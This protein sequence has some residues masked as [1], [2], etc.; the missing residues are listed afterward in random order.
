[1]TQHHNIDLGVLGNWVLEVRRSYRDNPFHNWYHGF[2]VLH[3]TY[4]S[5]KV[6]LFTRRCSVRSLM[7][8]M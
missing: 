6:P 1:M 2:S 5:L 4:L 3:F 8:L 7:C